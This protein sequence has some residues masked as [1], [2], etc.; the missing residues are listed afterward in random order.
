V[1]AA[2]FQIF[3]DDMV[4]SKQQLAIG[5]KNIDFKESIEATTVADFDSE[6]YTE[7]FRT[8]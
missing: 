4:P 8:E 1:L 5:D 3:A 7:E 6:F 2:Y